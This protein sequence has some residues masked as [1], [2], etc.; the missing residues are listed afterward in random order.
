MPGFNSLSSNNGGSA[1]SPLT[2]K[3]DLLTHNGVSPVR[4]PDGDVNGMALLVDTTTTTGLRYGYY[5]PQPQYSVNL[6][7]D[8]LSQTST[9]QLNWALSS[10]NGG[11]FVAATPSNPSQT[12]VLRLS[13]GSNSTARAAIQLGNL[14]LG[15]GTITLEYKLQVLSQSNAGD[16]FTVI[17][18]LGDISTAEPNNG[19]YFWYQQTV[20]GNFWTVKTASGGVRSKIVTSMAVNANVWYTLSMTISNSTLASFTLSNGTTSQTVTLNA[21]IPAFPQAS[22][23]A[24]SPMVG[25]TK[26]GGTFDRILQVDSFLLNRVYI[27]FSPSMLSGC[28]VWL[29]AMD[30][31]NAD[32]NN[33][34]QWNNKGLLGGEF[35]PMGVPPLINYTGLASKP[36]V[37]FNGTTQGLVNSSTSTAL[38]TVLQNKPGVTVFAVW[39]TTSLTTQQALFSA[40]T[41][42]NSSNR[43]LINTSTT[44][45]ISGAYRRLDADSIA[46]FNSATT[47]TSGTPVI[48]CFRMDNGV[49]VEHYVNNVL[50]ATGTPTLGTGNTSDTA[51]VNVSVGAM[52]NGVS[53]LTGAM[54]SLLVYDRALSA[55]EIT[56]VFTFLNGRWTVY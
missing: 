39:N 38:T 29:D 27:P 53:H 51:S 54:G 47:V 52:N 34:L 3:G 20:D 40:K 48:S 35:V 13:T 32:G 1:T 14:L 28:Q 45:L 4:L 10:A 24:V 2:S 42:G 15:S 23:V 12:G 56:E 37:T 31:I 11:F 36:A 7:D 16:I 18:G 22:A 9:G 8:F 55:A 6:S 46:T 44:G 41:T 26:A 30:S 49:V 21:N 43:L 17:A 25:I 50:S 33:V 5:Q 19:V